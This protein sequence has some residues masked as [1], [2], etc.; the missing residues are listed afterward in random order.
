MKLI[1]AFRH[2]ANA[3]RNDSALRNTGLRVPLDT[4]KTTDAFA[5]SVGSSARPLNALVLDAPSC[6]LFLDMGVKHGSSHEGG[7]VG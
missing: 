5:G 2:F 3:P 1:V 4:E 7:K 6:C